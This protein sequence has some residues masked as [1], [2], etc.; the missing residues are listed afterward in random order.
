M[1]PEGFSSRLLARGRELVAGTSYRWHRFPDGQATFGADGGGWILVSNSE[2]GALSD[3][4]ASALRFDAGGSIAAAYRI[5]GGTDANCAG[6]RTPWGTWLSCEEYSGGRVWECDPTGSSPAVVRPAMGVF[7]HEAAAVD[8]AGK[9][10]YMTEDESDGAFY[11]FTPSDYPSLLAGALELAK[12]A[13]DGAV[14]WVPVPDPSAISGPTRYQV[15]GATAFGGGEGIWFDGG[16]VYFTT[17]RDNKIHVYDTARATLDVIYDRALLADPPLSGLD[18]ITVAPSGDLYVCEDGGDMDIGLLVPD[19]PG[20][21]TRWTVSRFCKLTGTDHSSSEL[22]GVVFD[23]SGSR[24]YFS[25]QRA[26]GYG[27]VYEV[28]GPFRE[29]QLGRVAGT[30]GGAPQAAPPPE[31]IGQGSAGPSLTLRAPPG[32]TL[33][34]LEG[35]GLSVE[36]RGDATDVELVLRTPDLDFVP[37]ERGSTERPLLTTLARGEVE[38]GRQRASRALLTADE[39]GVGGARETSSLRAVL[40]AQGSDAAGRVA[41]ATQPVELIARP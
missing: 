8:P 36:V 13:S 7:K 17:K 38:L 30:L 26:F 14:T 27:A 16:F 20:N 1:L 12:I 34:R 18:N 32:V 3:G 15:T 31:S 9:R 6:G 21:P 39:E 33:R 28:S 29:P 41:I 40:T 37:G 23:P 22:A 4:G 11:R 5:L 10:L 25:S 24:V 19:H 2:S 35:E